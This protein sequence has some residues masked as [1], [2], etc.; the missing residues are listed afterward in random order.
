MAGQSVASWLRGSEELMTAADEIAMELLRQEGLGCIWQLRV[1]ATRVYREGERDAAERLL[2]I[3]DVAEEMFR[4]RVQ[5]Q[6]R[7]AGLG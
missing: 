6:A 4:R 7:A 1:H 5:A 2:E 3:A